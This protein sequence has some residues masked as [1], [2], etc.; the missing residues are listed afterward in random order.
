MGRWAFDELE[1]QAQR[2][3]LSSTGTCPAGGL[4]EAIL[5]DADG[6]NSVTPGDRLSLRLSNCYVPLLKSALTGSVDIRVGTA[7]ASEGRAGE[8]R[9]TSSGLRATSGSTQEITFFG[10]LAFDGAVRDDD[11]EMAISP[12][13]GTDLAL[14]FDTANRRVTER[15]QPT[16]LQHRMNLLT[17]RY[18]LSATATLQSE[19]LNGQVVLTTIDSLGGWATAVPDAARL[20]LAGRGGSSLTV[21]PQIEGNANQ[22]SVRIDADGNGVAEAQSLLYWGDIFDG[23]LWWPQA[24]PRPGEVVQPLAQGMME[25]V[26]LV[27]RQPSLTSTAL[28]PSLTV[29]FTLPLDPAA[30]PQ[31]KLVRFPAETTDDD[32]GDAEVGLSA[33]L[34]GT[35][36]TLTSPVQLQP[37][38]LY[39]WRTRAPGSTVDDPRPQVRDALGRTNDLPLASL[40]TRT[41]F[42]ARADFALG[43]F[44]DAQPGDFSLVADRSL[45]TEKG[46]VSYRW[47]QVS[48]PPATIL[49]PT[50]Q[51]TL[52]RLANPAPTV[53]ATVV[54][55]LT[56]TNGDGEIDISRLAIDLAPMAEIPSLYYRSTPGSYVGSGKVRGVAPSRGFIEFVSSDR[57][58]LRGAWEEPPPA[59]GQATPRWD[60]D[61]ILPPGQSIMP[62]TYTSALVFFGAE[63]QSASWE[64]HEVRVIEIAW[65]SA[66]KLTKLALD[67]GLSADSSRVYGSLRLN[68]SIAVRP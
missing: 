58:S 67:F 36:L 33:S 39:S 44:A 54:V 40:N 68:S 22:A 23:Y 41:T 60:F 29:D 65:D 52:L 62:G 34:T 17:A 55:E 7:A 3:S 12:L 32:W 16:A 64:Q 57:S 53:P 4:R 61:F 56:V 43:A 26:F 31:F 25:P 19:A 59:P 5:T 15:L 30:L 14:A 2:G 24:R 1:A 49:A 45:D 47:Q 6:S 13:P 20:R 48:G 50:A 27:R 66:G 63:Q 21:L 10:G 28:R 37:G 18:T 35:R 51:R 38:R 42:Q 9:V 8:L 11:T 46:I